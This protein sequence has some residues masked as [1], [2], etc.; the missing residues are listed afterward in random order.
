[1]SFSLL[2]VTSTP[3][4]SRQILQSVAPLRGRFSAIRT[5]HSCSELLLCA[6]RDMPDI[7][8]T[9]LAL[10]DSNALSAIHALKQQGIAPRTVILSAE[11]NFE[12][13]YTALLYKV[14][15]FLL[16]PL[17]EAH[18]RSAL[19][20]LLG[21][22]EA[23]SASLSLLEYRK[24]IGRLFL[25][26][27]H[28]TLKDGQFPVEMLNELYNT[29]FKDGAYRMVVVTMDRSEHASYT[30]L[31]K[32]LDACIN[33]LFGDVRRLCYDVVM[34]YAG[35][36]VHMLLNY[37]PECS[38]Q[39]TAALEHRLSYTTQSLPSGMTVTFCC[40]MQ[41]ESIQDLSI[42]AEE[43]MDAAWTRFTRKTSGLLTKKS[44]SPCPPHVDK[45]YSSAE[46]DL[47]RACFEL[48]L[49]DFQ[50]R[51]QQLFSLPKTVISRSETRHLLRRVEAYMLENNKDLIAAF[52]NVEVVK[53]DLLRPMQRANSLEEYTAKYTES[54]VTLFKHI[55]EQAGGSQSRHIHLA[56]QYIDAHLADAIHLND[57]ADHVG[58]SP[59]YMSAL[60]KKQTGCNF[61]NYVNIRRVEAAKE[62][63]AEDELKVQAIADALGFYDSH[64][65][66]RV[67]KTV[68][69]MNPTQYR[70]SVSKK[71]RNH[72]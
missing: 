33:A 21:K 65:F 30:M 5:V 15:F 1:M 40:S 38:D 69:G 56:K 2:L 28:M 51:L 46:E 43:S 48:N 59:V 26:K 66:S 10:P 27:A 17:D 55:L 64:Y 34:R 62:L 68:T 29:C 52:T 35:K 14:D 23:K 60:F 54:M 42:M 31:T 57:V 18:L 47:K 22:L 20:E 36:R 24:V 39:V 11:K 53:N 44:E 16:K 25:D 19:E 12:E 9:E 63:L 6:K 4:S 32:H 70:T 41:H 50:N 72:P 8:I 67:F 7:I 58:L 3:E 37:P 61:S 45:L 71:R 13:A 49:E